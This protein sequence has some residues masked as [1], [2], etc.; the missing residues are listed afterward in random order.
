MKTGMIMMTTTRRLSVTRRL[1]GFLLCLTATYCGVPTTQA[2]LPAPA[3]PDEYIVVL[4][5]TARGEEVAQQH[6]LV[7]RHQ[8]QHALHGFA[9]HIPAGRL[10]ALR[11][12]PRV[13]FIE[14]DI[15]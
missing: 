3:I 13:A 4:K 11:Y 14:Q 5:A 12:D 10:Q 9:G 1:L 15:E 7:A 2:Q 8:Y 6:G